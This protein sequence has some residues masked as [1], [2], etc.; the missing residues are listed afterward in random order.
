MIKDY[1]PWLIVVLDDTPFYVISYSLK[2]LCE[3]FVHV[4]VNIGDCDKV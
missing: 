3:N 2:E 1:L 4:H